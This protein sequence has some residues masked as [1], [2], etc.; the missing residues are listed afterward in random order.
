MYIW[1]A[2]ATLLENLQC[3]KSHLGIIIGHLYSFLN[4]VLLLY[5]ITYGPD[6]L[7]IIIYINY[8]FVINTI[9][10]IKKAFFLPKYYITY[11]SVIIRTYEEQMIKADV[12]NVEK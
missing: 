3:G 11:R 9:E 1:R 8:G 2:S 10:K 4:D 12:V 7:L 6:H 5:I